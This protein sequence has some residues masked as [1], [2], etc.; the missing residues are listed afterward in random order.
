L[1]AVADTYDAITSDR[2]YRRAQ[3]HAAAVA[4]IQRVSGTQL[5]PRVVNAFTAVPEEEWNRIRGEVEQ[6][7]LLEAQWG[8]TPPK[9]VFDLI[10]DAAQKAARSEPLSPDLAAVKA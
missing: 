2:P 8:W 10:R 5:D 9:R 7:S 1:F 4:E 6:I 3:S